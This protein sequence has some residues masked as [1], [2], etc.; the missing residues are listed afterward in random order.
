MEKVAN[1]RG[2]EEIARDYLNFL[3]STKGQ[4][5]HYDEAVVKANADRFPEVKLYKVED[6]FGSWEN[7]QETHF[8]SG[9][10]LDELQRQ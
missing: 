5:I 2:T 7:A 6:V 10:V 9:G 3:Y 4:A 8:A 1:Q